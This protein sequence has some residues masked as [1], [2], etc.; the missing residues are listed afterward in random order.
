MQVSR[1]TGPVSY[2]LATGERVHARRLVPGRPGYME[3]EGLPVSLYP[4]QGSVLPDPVPVP[5]AS[6]PAGEGRLEFRRPSPVP[7][8]PAVAAP[9]P[10][11]ELV[12]PRRSGRVRRSP[13]RYSP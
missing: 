5:V 9:A 6:S 13:A 2:R 11:Q 1:Q 3:G 4:A 8:A 7:V 10:T 12:T